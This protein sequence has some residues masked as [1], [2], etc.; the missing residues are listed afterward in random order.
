[1]SKARSLKVIENGCEVVADR[2]VSSLGKGAE[3]LQITSKSPYADFV[4]PVRGVE[5]G[6]RW[7]VAGIKDGMVFDRLTGK[8]GMMLDDYIKLFDYSSDLNFE[9]TATRTLK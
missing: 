4:G 5:S 3:Y 9:I 7:H 6:W 8:A 2:V 1:M